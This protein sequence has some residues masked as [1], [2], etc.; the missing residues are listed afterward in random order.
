MVKKMQMNTDTLFLA[1][2]LNF[3]FFYVDLLFFQ[4]HIVKDGTVYPKGDTRKYL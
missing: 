3:F 1:Y 4:H 2:F